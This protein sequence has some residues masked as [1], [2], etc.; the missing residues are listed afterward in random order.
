MRLNQVLAVESNV[1]AKSKS[2]NEKFYH[3]IQKADLFNGTTRIFQP[4]DSQ[5][6]GLFPDESIRVKM[7]VEDE[8]PKVA[9]AWEELMNITATKDFANSSE[10]ARSSVV[11]DG[12]V[13]VEDAPVPFLLWLEKQ[14]TDL[15]TVLLK[16]P[17]I[18]PAHHWDYDTDSKQWRARERK[19]IKSKK[20]EVPLVMYEATTEHPAQVKTIVEDVTIGHWLQT[21]LSG[22]VSQSRKDELVKRVEKLQKAVKKS[23]EQANMAEV[24]EKLVGGALFGY[25]FE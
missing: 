2:T 13:I 3:A 6:E 24:E 11:V 20:T 7:K 18:D 9:H 4:L 12:T 22:G 25:L 5:H 14:L 19:V 1:K 16:L 15:H 10:G 17:V 21:D 23:R 8:L